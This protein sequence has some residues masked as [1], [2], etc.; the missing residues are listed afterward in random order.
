MAET[1]RKITL[2]QYTHLGLVHQMV[3]DRLI[4]RKEWEIVENESSVEDRG[5]C[6]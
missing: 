4:E 1:V 6:S 2:D 3:V 5:S